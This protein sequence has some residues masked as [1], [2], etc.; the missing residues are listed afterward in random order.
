MLTICALLPD[1][2]AMPHAGRADAVSA[3]AE[4]AAGIHLGGS[5]ELKVRIEDVHQAA[6]AGCW[7]SR[8]MTVNCEGGQTFRNATYTSVNG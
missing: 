3:H 8:D 4:L 7:A 2:A 6:A 5:V 1:L